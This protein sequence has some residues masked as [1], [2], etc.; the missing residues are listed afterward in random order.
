[1]LMKTRELCDELRIHQNTLYRW[2]KKYPDF[3]SSRAGLHFRFDFSAV[4][5]WFNKHQHDAELWQKGD[6]DAETF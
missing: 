3:P 4:Q 1:M 2:I 6:V 5:R